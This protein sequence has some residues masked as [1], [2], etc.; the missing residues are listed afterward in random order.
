[1]TLLDLRAASQ[2]KSAVADL[3]GVYPDLL[4]LSDSL[5]LKQAIRFAIFVQLRANHAV[6]AAKSRHA[7]SD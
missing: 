1:M 5:I 2:G 6:D 7:F 3:L 4:R